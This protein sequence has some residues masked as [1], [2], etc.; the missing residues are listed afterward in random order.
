M[1]HKYLVQLFAV[2]ESKPVAVY[3]LRIL[4]HICDH[5]TYQFVKENLNPF[6]LKLGEN[7]GVDLET[8]VVRLSK[9]K[10]SGLFG[11]SNAMRELVKQLVG[12]K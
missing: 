10:L 8:L 7:E 6:L 5:S 3:A 1:F 12:G 11:N 4:A 9:Y 2:S